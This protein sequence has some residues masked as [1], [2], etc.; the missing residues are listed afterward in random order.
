LPN[1][2]EE[3]ATLSG[4]PKDAASWMLGEFMQAA[5][6]QECEPQDLHMPAQSLATLIA[7]SPKALSTATPPKKSLPQILAHKV[8][9]DTYIEQN[10]LRMVSNPDALKN[11]TPRLIAANPQSI[12]DYKAGKTKARGFLV[13]QVM[14]AMQ[15]KA[16]PQLLNELLQDALG[17]GVRGINRMDSLKHPRGTVSSLALGWLDS[18]SMNGHRSGSAGCAGRC[19]RDG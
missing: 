19:H 14:K 3:T 1:L 7:A 18:R 10:G 15:G 17:E 4:R 6:E 2:F 8:D 11:K 9:P 13:G 12:V 5:K 16:D